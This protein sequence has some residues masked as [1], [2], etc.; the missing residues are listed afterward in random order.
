[1]M[2]LLIEEDFSFP[3]LV[4]VT[5]F[6]VYYLFMVLQISTRQDGWPRHDYSDETWKMGDRTFLNTLEQM[7]PFLLPMWLFALFISPHQAGVLGTIYV[8][9]RLLFPVFWGL[10]GGWTIL[11][12]VSTQPQYAVIASF[13]VALAVKAA[14]GTS[15]F[16]HGAGWDVLAFVCSFIGFFVIVFALGK[17]LVLIAKS[18]FGPTGDSQP[19]TTSTE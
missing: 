15:I 2:K 19:V 16:G 11:V 9:F 5:Y 8:V 6:L 1:M 4:T 17:L 18:G 10:R 12:E 14:A 13:Y 3:V 7:V